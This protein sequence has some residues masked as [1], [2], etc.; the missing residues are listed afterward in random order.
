M[1][2]ISQIRK[3]NCN[4]ILRVIFILERTYDSVRREVLYNILFEFGVLTTLVRLL[5]LCLNETCNKVCV[6]K[7]LLEAF[8]IQNGLKQGHDLSPF[9]FN[10]ALKYDIRKVQGS[11]ERLELNNTSATG[12]C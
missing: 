4:E 6:C 10:F 7:C 11:G 1:F 2:C 3:K 12:L 9:L 5:K 8:S